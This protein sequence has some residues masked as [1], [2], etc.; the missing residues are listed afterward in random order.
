M[1]RRDERVARAADCR[2]ATVKSSTWVWPG[3]QR[4]GRGHAAD[5]RL[6][7]AL[8]H[9]DADLDARRAGPASPMLRTE[10][11][12]HRR[13]RAAHGQ[14]H[15]GVGR[16][17]HALVLH[18]LA[19][20]VQPGLLPVVLL[21]RRDRAVHVRRIASAVARIADVRD[22]VGVLVPDR[23]RADPGVLLVAPDGDAAVRRLG[24]R[25]LGPGNVRIVRARVRPGSTARCRTS[26]R[27]SS[28]SAPLEIM[29]IS[30]WPS[31]S[32]SAT[33]DASV[34]VNDVGR[35]GQAARARS[36]RRTPTGST[37]RCRRPPPRPSPWKSNTLEPV[38]DDE[39]SW[40]GVCHTTSIVGG[41]VA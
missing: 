3:Q 13:R 7:A 39:K 19:E 10:T 20:V 27:S 34:P 35:L 28:G 15:G 30:A 9:V 31:P 14:R 2:P 40:F 17:E 6:D 5:L 12:T 21:V 29:T 41:L 1:M 24:R 38:T 16:I 18:V 36:G 22:V 8:D 37:R 26:S 25:R 32:T 23:A 33:S 11:W 4:L